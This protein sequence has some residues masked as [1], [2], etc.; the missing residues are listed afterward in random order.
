MILLQSNRT[1]NSKEKPKGN[2]SPPVRVPEPASSCF[3]CRGLRG[4]FFPTD[5][6]PGLPTRKTTIWGDSLKQQT[7]NVMLQRRD[8]SNKTTLLWLWLSEIVG[9]PQMA[10]ARSVNGTKDENSCGPIPGGLILTHI[11]MLGAHKNLFGGS[12]PSNLRRD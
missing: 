1:C 12:V 7:H 5:Q 11:H 8:L 3:A 6:T 2:S 4:I 10:G 9:N